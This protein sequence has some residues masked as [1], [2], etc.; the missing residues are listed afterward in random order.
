MAYTP[1]RHSRYGKPTI[2]RWLLCRRTGNGQLALANRSIC[3]V[4]ITGPIPPDCDGLRLEPPS[5]ISFPFRPQRQH[6][7]SQ[8]RQP[9]A[10]GLQAQQVELL[11]ILAVNA[12]LVTSVADIRMA[13]RRQLPLRQLARIQM[14]LDADA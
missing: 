14:L 3:T 12:L 8:Q 6:F 4:L 11:H 2:T 10:H 9:R 7:I 13:V 5:F 1:G